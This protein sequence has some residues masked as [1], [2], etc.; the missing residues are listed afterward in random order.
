ME[1]NPHSGSGLSG[2]R[3]GEAPTDF[4]S[5]K[6][7]AFHHHFVYGPVDS[8]N[9]GFVQSVAFGEELEWLITGQ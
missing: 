1:A 5:G 6:N 3:L 8:F 4:V 7:L 2:Q 9:H